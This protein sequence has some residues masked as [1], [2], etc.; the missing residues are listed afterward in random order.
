MFAT[1]LVDWAQKRMIRRL[2]KRLEPARSSWDAVLLD[3]MRGPAGAL[4]WV[5]GI[6]F[7]MEIMRKESGAAIFGA[8]RPI[9]DVGVILILSWFLIRF[10]QGAERNIV[11][12]RL[13]AGVPIDRTTADVVAKLLRLSVII[14]ALL[15]ILQTL[16]YSISGVLAF[17]GIGGIVA[18]FAARDLL[19]NFF[20]GLMI[21]LDRPF[22]V[23]DWIR[24]P[25]KEIEGV[26]EHIGWCLTRILTFDRCPL[27]VPNA[28]FT[29]IAV[30][31][32]SRMSNRRIYEAIG[33]R[34]CD[35]AKTA[36]IVAD[37]KGMLENHP[38]IGAD[39]TVIANFSRFAPSSLDFFVSAYTKTTDSAKYHAVKQDVMLKIIDIIGR[40]GAECAFPAFTLQPA[41]GKPLAAST[42][43]GG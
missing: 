11:Q 4:V 37:I 14:T 35:A 19:A 5:I 7:A 9:R 39:Q 41:A 43:S 29:S 20:G 3:T 38:D 31:N 42:P 15:V 23:G 36:P 18:G 21:Y 2:R 6:A 10:I 1:V 17:G 27:Y 8:V 25:D 22:A 28:V 33:I 16:G 32:P 30:E 12:V 34:Y 26:V 24:S 40:R 13:E